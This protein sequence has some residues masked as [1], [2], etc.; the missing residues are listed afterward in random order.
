MIRS[1]WKKHLTI[2]ATILALNLTFFTAAG[3][4]D[5]NMAVEKGDIH[6][7]VESSLWELE[8]ELEKG[9]MAAQAFAQSRNIRIGHQNKVTVYLISE[10]GRT[11]DETSLQAYGA[12]VMKSADNVW[13]ARVPITML[14]TIADTVEGVSFIKLPDRPIPLAIESEGV[15]LTGASIYHSAGYTGSD[16]KVAVIDLG[17]AGLSSAISDSE[18]PNT[19]VMIDCTGSS[20]VPTDFSSETELH[21][22]ACAEIVYDMAPETE[23]YLIKIEDTLDLRDAKDY[24]IANGIKVISHSVGWVNTNFYSGECYYSN[25][26]C[27]AKDAYS[28]GIL[29]VNAMGNHAEG[30][31][32]ATFTDS[33][34]NRW[35]NVSGDDETI[36]IAANAGDIIQVALTWNAWPYTDQ[37]YDL[38][39]GYYYKGSFYIDIVAWSE[40]RQ[41]GTQPPTELISYSVSVTGTYYLGIR[42][43]SATSDHQLELFSANHYTYPAVA[44]SSI[45]SPADAIGVMAVGAINHGNWTTGPQEPFSSQ[46]PT[47]DGRTKPE[48]SGPDGVS[49]YTYGGNFPGTSAATPHVAG[50]AALFLSKN[51]TY[52]ISQLWVALTSSAVNMGSSGQDNIYGYGRLSLPPIPPTLSTGSAT[53]VTTNSATLNGT[54]NPNRESTTYYFEYGTTASYGSATTETDAG[55]G[56]EEVSASA[57]IAGLSEGTSYHFRLVATNTIGTNYGEDATFT[58]TTTPPTVSSTTPANNATDVGVNTALTATFSEEMD[59]SS[60]TTDT[61]LGSGSGNIAG[62]VTYSDTRATFTPTTALN[63][64][65]TY[66]A[67]ITTGAEDLAGN[68]L[69]ADHTWSFTTESET[70]GV[71]GNG[72][73]GAGAGDGGGGGCFIATAA[74]GSS[75]AEE[76]VALRKFRENV[77]LRNSLGR[78]FVKS[79]H[80]ISPPLAHSIRDHQISRTATILALTPVIYGA[81]HTK[82]FVLI[83]LLSV[84]AIPL[85]L[86]MWV[87]KRF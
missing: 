8:K 51:P 56:T 26:V 32:K 55:S 34:G 84:M 79:Y 64:N 41:P 46:G 76:V 53:S 28:N 5:L 36:N 42:K 78:T 85:S 29:W 20:C 27:T 25:P 61:F 48:I 6:P 60:I 45:I 15:G 58:T 47:N 49:S 83:F 44:S 63:Y 37:D 81:K 54:V 2:F 74:Y 13:K 73:D 7:K 35:H 24:A 57:D 1:R 12:E 39:L 3:A 4:Q 75:M 21:G 14:A 70:D 72:G 9:A 66:T 33:D 23:L 43:Y 67:T 82:T 65:T 30:H 86:R 31:Y 68:S 17:F 10:P 87:S 18:L 80:E 19:V 38:Y 52:S 77:L 40:T 16:V 71:P 50:A 62:T 11:I 22:T 59:A 69:Q